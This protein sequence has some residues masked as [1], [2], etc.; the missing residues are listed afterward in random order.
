MN[1]ILNMEDTLD[2]L[3]IGDPLF[4]YWGVFT[5]GM[6][7]LK[8][9]F[10]CLKYE[11]NNNENHF[12]ETYIINKVSKEKVNNTFYNNLLFQCESFLN[13][14]KINLSTHDLQ[15]VV[16]NK[17]ENYYEIQVADRKY[18]SY[19]IIFN[20]DL[21]LVHKMN[22]KFINGHENLVLKN[23]FENNNYTKIELFEKASNTVF[24]VA[25]MLKDEKLYTIIPHSTT[26]S[27][28]MLKY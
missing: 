8:T 14:N 1:N 20:T 12:Y 28:Q 21:K 27:K 24:E 16:I 5:A 2:I 19:V 4:C 3:F 22:L 25:K 26:L 17:K 9:N 6:L 10:I 15:S 18:N 23:C 11:N 7:K 13:S